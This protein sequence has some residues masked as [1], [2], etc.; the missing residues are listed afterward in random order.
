MET[1]K[2]QATTDTRQQ[3][4]DLRAAVDSLGSFIFMK[5]LQGRYTYVNERVR[6]LFG[7][8]EEAILGRDDSTFFSLDQSRDLRENDE[9]VLRQGRAIET[10]ERNVIAA[11]GEER[12]FW[13]VKRPLVSA[14]GS[15]HG[16][17]GASTDITEKVQL[18][19]ALRE[20]QALL[21]T[22]LDHAPA[23]IYLKDTDRRYVYLNHRTAALY[24]YDPDA[25]VGARDEDLLS[26]GT[27]ENCR[28]LD[29]RVLATYAPQQGEETFTAA[30]G[31]IRVYE[32]EKV[33]LLS[34]DG[35]F[36]G[37]IGFSRDMTE[38]RQLQQ[39]LER[40]AHEDQLTGL[41]N[42]R[43]TEQVLEEELNRAHR[44]GQPLSLLA[45]DLDHFKSVNDH[46]GHE[47]GD[48]V[49]VQLGV[50]LDERLRSTDTLGRW[51]GEEFFVILPDTDLEG[52]QQVAETLRQTTETSIH[53]GDTPVTVSIG[54]TQYD[55]S[56]TLRAFIQHADGLLYR[57]KHSGRNQV[58]LISSQAAFR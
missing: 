24:G 19:R 8:P 3:L 50:I 31:R 58:A 53:A 37:F 11:T 34:E 30:D 57:A 7:L 15:I 17:S 55:H 47:M 22:V 41:P 25:I 45:L 52:A 48:Q 44:S 32:T 40:M 9:Q 29:D 26:H 12:W 20:K 36:T 28:G 13:T 10:Q 49:L 42:R 54:V 39:R 21:E 14:D 35:T 23:C 16:M 4:D 1:G 6:N 5:D 2:P 33:P 38:T 27:A 18:E 43:R 51:G 46:Y 56:Q